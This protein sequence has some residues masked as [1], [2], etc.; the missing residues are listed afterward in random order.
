MPKPDRAWMGHGNALPPNFK[1]TTKNEYWRAFCYASSL[2]NERRY[3]VRPEVK[4]TNPE[5]Y[6]ANAVCFIND[7]DKTGFGFIIKVER[8][9]YVE[10]DVY[11]KFA[12]CE[13][14]YKHENV[15]KCL[16]E[17]TCTKCGHAYTVDSSD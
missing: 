9:A 15:G 17:Y 6:G 2:D 3:L 5:L 7:F 12:L 16:H 8:A 11:F 14:E 13:H 1:L 10:P 4:E